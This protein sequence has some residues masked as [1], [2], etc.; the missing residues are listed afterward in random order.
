MNSF[1]YKAIDRSGQPIQGRIEAQS[2]QAAVAVLADGGHFVTEINPD[3]VSPGA[4]PEAAAV[5]TH[6]LR[7]SEKHRAEFVDQMANVLQSKLPLIICLQ[8]VGQQNPHAKIKLLAGEIDKLV[9]SGQSLSSAMAQFPRVFDALHLYLI[10]AGETGGFLDQ[11]MAQLA[12]L[13]QR[14]LE[15]RN[16]IL[17]AMLYPIFVLSLGLVSLGVI[18][19][20]ILPQIL[21]SLAA[22]LTVLPWPTRMVLALSH[23]SKF[24]FVAIIAALVA[25]SLIGPRWKK[26]AW[27]RYLWDSLILR[28]PILSAV[29]KKWA[30]AGFARTLGILTRSGIDILQSLNIVRNTLNNEVFAREIDHIAKQ[31]RMGS[32]LAAPLRQS[33]Q[34]PPLLTQIVTV[35]EETGQL[36]RLLLNTAAV[37]DKETQ[38]AVKRFMA[39]FP[40]LLI[41]VLALFVGFIVAAMLLPIVQMETALPGF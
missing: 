4:R 31:V 36:D 37:F 27:G 25:V 41:L 2:Q 34:F 10:K 29:K 30:V 24:V 5:K 17:T 26:T 40:A 28:I 1:R 19:T 11:S 16:S 22:D 6:K 20:W 14:R 13:N 32:S 3:I 23:L 8:I 7:L 33:R 38:T 15:I 9:R 35:G 21:S 18:V 39:I 12:D